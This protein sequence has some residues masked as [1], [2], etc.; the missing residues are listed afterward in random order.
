[1]PFFRLL[2]FSW[3]VLQNF[4]SHHH[5]TIFSLVVWPSENLSWFLWIF[6]FNFNKKNEK[7]IGKTTENKENHS[8]WERNKLF[9]NPHN[10][11]NARPRPG[12]LVHL[13]S[14]RR[15]FKF[16]FFWYVFSVTISYWII[17]FCTLN[18]EPF[19]QKCEWTFI[20]S[21]SFANHR[22]LF[23]FYEYWLN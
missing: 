10:S 23:E 19:E 1:M 20:T 15:L 9:V 14:F 11:R 21:V 16:S 4:H 6:L 5:N 17:I 2:I 18:A 3:W 13:V 8:N 22:Y 12:F 7:P